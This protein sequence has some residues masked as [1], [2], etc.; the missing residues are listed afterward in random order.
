[1][2]SVRTR[3]AAGDSLVRAALRVV[4][5]AVA[6]GLSSQSSFFWCVFCFFVFFVFLFFFFFFFFFFFVFGRRE[7]SFPVAGGVRNGGVASLE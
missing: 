7:V 4:L 5:S 1:M 6:G 3:P 2:A